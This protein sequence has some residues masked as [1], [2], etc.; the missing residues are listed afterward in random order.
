MENQVQ[1]FNDKRVLFKA[2]TKFPHIFGG[3]LKANKVKS[4]RFSINRNR[5]IE[6]YKLQRERGNEYYSYMAT[7]DVFTKI[8][9]RQQ[10]I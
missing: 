10:K 4:Q 1:I 5:I 8:S 2:G 7:R 3:S 9:E 6:G